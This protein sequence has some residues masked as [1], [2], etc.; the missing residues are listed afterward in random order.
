MAPCDRERV[1]VYGWSDARQ[2]ELRRKRISRF[3]SVPRAL[4][5]LLDELGIEDPPDPLPTS[6]PSPMMLKLL[7]RVLPV[8]LPMFA[9]GSVDQPTSDPCDEKQCHSAALIGV[10]NACNVW[11]GLD[12]SSGSQCEWLRGPGD[13]P[14]RR[15]AAVLIMLAAAVRTGAMAWVS[16]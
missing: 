15:S 1:F 12:N 10:P 5:R 7:A 6:Q 3:L 8:A 16:G 4:K 14:R 2:T 9:L 13:E 11:V